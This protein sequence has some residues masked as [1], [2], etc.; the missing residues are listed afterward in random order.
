MTPWLDPGRAG[1]APVELGEIFAGLFGADA[2]VRFTA[3]DGSAAGQPDAQVSIRLARPRAAAYLAT[4]PGSLGVVRAYLRD[5]I[6]VEGVHPGNPYP[7]MRLFEDDMQI[8]APTPMQAV[9]WLR[10]LGLRTL[11]PPSLPSQEVR[12]RPFDPRHGKRRDAAAIS[13]HYDVSNRF[14]EMVL[15]PSMAYTC[16]C[17]PSEDASLEQ[18]Q[19]HKHD[20]VARKLGLQPGMR[21]LDVGCGWGGMVRHAAKNY[22]VSVLG[23]TLSA[24]QAKWARVRNTAEGLDNLVE[25]RHLDYRDVT[26]KGF[27]AVSSIGL[28]EHIGVNNYPAYFRFLRSRL[29]PGGSLLNHGITRPDNRHPGLRR[30]G[31]IGK[32]VFPDGELTG[33]GDIVSAMED[34]GLEVQHQENLRVHYARTLKRWCENLEENWDECVAEADL[35]T[36]KIWGL[37][38]AGS[39]LAFERNGIQLHQVLATRTDALGENCYPLRPHFE[40]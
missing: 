20:M 32:Y 36:A 6:E 22:G 29:R 1:A 26:E 13:H 34:A 31:F 23:V 8:H 18:A 3:Y 15:G 25:V 30:R 2:P 4:A 14:Y 21:L 39:R 28:I 7:L 33:S 16:A 11:V 9:R 17:Y 12:P 40:T 27:D 35:A 24:E 10:G 19:D 5:D 37:Y 38:M